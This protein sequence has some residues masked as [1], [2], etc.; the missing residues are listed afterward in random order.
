MFFIAPFDPKAWEDP[1]DFSPKPTSD[2]RIEPSE[3]RQKLAERWPKI[4]FIH[5]TPT[6]WELPPESEG[7]SGLR[8]WLQKNQQIVSF[9]PGP[10]K[11][12]IDFVLWHRSVIP[13]QY[14]LYLFNSSSWDSFFLTKDSTEQDIIEFTGIIS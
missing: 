8:G 11:S 4:N 5:L 2:L 10:D 6:G 13:E 12:F 14:P 9:G 3:Y 1:D 7:Y